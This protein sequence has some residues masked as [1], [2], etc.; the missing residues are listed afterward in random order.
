[1][2][3]KLPST[4]TSI[5]LLSAVLVLGAPAQDAGLAAKSGGSAS[6]TTSTSFTALLDSLDNAHEVLA[7]LAENTP[8]TWIPLDPGR[9]TRDEDGLI[10]EF[11]LVDA[12]APEADGVRVAGLT[13]VARGTVAILIDVATETRWSDAPPLT[14]VT[15]Y[16]TSG[17]MPGGGSS[18][19]DPDPAA[20]R[21]L[22]DGGGVRLWPTED[23]LGDTGEDSS[24]QQTYCGQT[25]DMS[26]LKNCIESAVGP[27]DSIP[28]FLLCCSCGGFGGGSCFGI[29]TLDF[30]AFDDFTNS[31]IYNCAT[32]G[33][34]CIF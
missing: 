30:P 19:G 21:V 20:G 34:H 9:V 26:C 28:P 33:S 6:E 23:R 4:P 22:L 32:T 3:S 2:A 15:R 12:A 31:V 8:H 27:V 1:M 29:S 24:F 10:A 7:I 17:T 11:G 5:L 18:D 16:L 25:I 14:V 13:L